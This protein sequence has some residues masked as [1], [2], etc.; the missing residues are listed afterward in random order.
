[1]AERAKSFGYPVKNVE[2]PHD[3]HWAV[4]ADAIPMMF[5]WFDEQ[6]GL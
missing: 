3:N 5:D 6:P 2:F 4:V 1:M